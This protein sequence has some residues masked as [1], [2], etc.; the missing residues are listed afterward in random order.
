MEAKIN[1]QIQV[2]E[3]HVGVCSC[4]W[5]TCWGKEDILV[6]PRSFKG[7][8]E[9]PDLVFRNGVGVI[10]PTKVLT[11]TAVQWCVSGQTVTCV[12]A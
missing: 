2:K 8:F 11:K 12:K 1:S 3:M 10:V 5:L 6:G 4:S 7:L 9:G